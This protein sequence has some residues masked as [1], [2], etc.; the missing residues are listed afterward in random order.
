MIFYTGNRYDGWQG[1]VLVGS[2]RPGLLVRLT[3][4]DGRVVNEER[5]LAE[6]NQ[7]I[8][9]VEQGPDGFVYLVTDSPTGQILR[10]VPAT[11]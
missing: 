4:R 10:V 6:L 5:Y 9:D 11:P 2:L 3:L 1:S 7:R 8:R